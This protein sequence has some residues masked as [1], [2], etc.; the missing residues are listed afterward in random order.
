[1]VWAFLRLVL[2]E[3]FVL[4]RKTQAPGGACQAGQLITPESKA[5]AK[6]APEGQGWLCA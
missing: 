6:V 1:M 4:T 2:C 5:K 3:M